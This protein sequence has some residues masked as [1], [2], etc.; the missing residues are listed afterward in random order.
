MADQEEPLQLSQNNSPKNSTTPES[1][2][3]EFH[4]KHEQILNMTRT[5]LSDF[6]DDEIHINAPIQLR[7]V[8]NLEGKNA[9]GFD[10]VTWNIY[11][12]L[13]RFY[14]K[15]GLRGEKAWRTASR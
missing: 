6:R 12:T 4:G 5:A 10:A 13:I 8:Q 11:Q 7:F 9:G 2:D 15:Q 14:L 3:K 1:V